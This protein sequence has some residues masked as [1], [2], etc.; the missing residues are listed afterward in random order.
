MYVVSIT[1]LFEREQC[2]NKII[3]KRR[4][5]FYVFFSHDLWCFKDLHGTRNKMKCNKNT[6]QER[7]ATGT[8]G[9]HGEKVAVPNV[10]KDSSAIRQLAKIKTQDN[11]LHTLSQPNIYHPQHD[12]TISKEGSTFLC[13]CLLNVRFMQIYY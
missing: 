9:L 10:S 7:T 8:A 11:A 3:I 2:I 12:G 4:F 13:R 1:F 6:E 5:L